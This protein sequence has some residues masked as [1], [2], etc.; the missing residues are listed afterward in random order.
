MSRNTFQKAGGKLSDLLGMKL[1]ADITWLF[2][3]AVNTEI[4]VVFF[5]LQMLTI[6]STES[7]N[8]FCP[9]D[10]AVRAG[11][12]NIKERFIEN[13][14]F[15]QILMWWINCSQKIKVTWQI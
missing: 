3:S 4:F 8:N 14:G 7:T 1:T 13:D 10:R 6:K 9:S 2:L 12:V 5:L 11:K 15:L